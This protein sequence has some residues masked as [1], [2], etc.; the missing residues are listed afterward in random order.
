[1]AWPL[2]L[3]AAAVLGTAYGPISVLLALFG[4]VAVGSAAGGLPKSVSI[5]VVAPVIEELS[6]GM[7]F[8]VL[9]GLVARVLGALLRP[10]I[11]RGEDSLLGNAARFMVEAVRE[12][13]RGVSGPLVLGATTALVFGTIENFFYAVWSLKLGPLAPIVVGVTRTF[14]SLPVHVLA[15][16]SF[17]FLYGL[18][19]RVVG[20]RWVGALSGYVSAVLIHAAFN[21]SILY[22]RYK[23]V[24]A[25]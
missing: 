21:F 23:A 11:R 10:A 16:S 24:H 8:L 5:A 20:S 25:R 19:W 18:V 15:T 14:V 6:K 4:E 12:S 3:L 9:P 13:G 1:M 7:S 17:A 22:L 2:S